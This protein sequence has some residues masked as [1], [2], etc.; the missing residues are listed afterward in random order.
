MVA[1]DGASDQ[2]QLFR[3]PRWATR[4]Y[5]RGQVLGQRVAPGPGGVDHQRRAYIERGGAETVR[6]L[7]ADDA[8]PCPDPAGRLDVVDSHCAGGDGREHE[9]QHHAVGVVHLAVVPD[10]AACHPVRGDRRVQ[11]ETLVP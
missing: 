11:R 5:C 9:R 4:P 2:V 6:R 8:V 7:D 3:Q 1:R 10:D